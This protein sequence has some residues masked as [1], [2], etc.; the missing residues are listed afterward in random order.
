MF[1]VFG[2]PLH[3]LVVHAV[4]VLLP[5][6][7][8][9]L[10]ACVAVSRW[11]R[12][13]AGLSVLGLTAGAA[14]AF[15]A[16]ASG[17]ALAAQVGTPLAHQAIGQL[18]PWVAAATLALSAVWYFLQRGRDEQA[19]LVRGMGVLAAVAAAASIVVTVLVGHSGAT[20]VWG[21]TSNGAA[22][23][24]IGTA[25]PAASDQSYT[26]EQV[27][28]HNTRADCWA[29][30][31]D[32]VYN[33]TDWIGQ[34]PGGAEHIVALCGTDA[35]EAFAS[36]HSGDERPESQLTRFYIGALA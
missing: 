16:A 11:R 2:L 6:S 17:N 24:P 3:P 26:L 10:I 1:D 36:Q 25:S 8:L 21:G 9:G 27:R 35:T 20:A 32:G 30:I 34:H 14:S 31:D 28:Q 29:A 7:A 19:P 33:L 23:N 12:H 15:V 22:A 4:V 18:L 13:Y 5:L